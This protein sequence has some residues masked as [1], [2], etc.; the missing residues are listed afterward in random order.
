VVGFVTA[1]RARPAD[2]FE[3]DALVEHASFDLRLLATC[4]GGAQAIVRIS[5]LGGESAAA[6]RASERLAAAH[7][8]ATI[9]L[10]PGR[11]RGSGYYGRVALQVALRWPGCDEIEIADGG[12]VDWTRRLLSDEK[13]RLLI[14]G[15]GAE[16]LAVA[17]DAARGAARERGRA[18]HHEPLPPGGWD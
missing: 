17:L 1:G 12:D 6:E 2:A 4:A 18:P 13:E 9:A 7:A 11:R 5:A 3:E 15:A 8:D 14:S 16:R 10:D